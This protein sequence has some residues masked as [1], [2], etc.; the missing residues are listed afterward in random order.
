MAEQLNNTR[1]VCRKY[2]VHP[3]VFERYADGTMFETLGRA[4]GNGAAPAGLNPEEKAV[5]R[6]LAT[7]G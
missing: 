7:A 6:L 2:Y 4:G 1:A 5:V 3:T